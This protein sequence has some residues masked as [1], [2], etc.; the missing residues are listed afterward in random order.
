MHIIKYLNYSIDLFFKLPVNK[1]LAINIEG[2]I[3]HPT[4]MKSFIVK[5]FY[6][7]HDDIYIFEIS[8]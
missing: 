8:V 7:V 6:N 4:I 2:K 3:G 1:Y 5:I